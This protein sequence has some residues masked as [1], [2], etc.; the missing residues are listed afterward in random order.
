[1]FGPVSLISSFVDSAWWSQQSQRF[2]VSLINL[3]QFVY[4]VLPC[5]WVAG[6]WFV[7]SFWTEYAWPY[8]RYL[9]CLHWCQCRVVYCLKM[10][11]PMVF[12]FRHAQWLTGWENLVQFVFTGIAST[13]LAHQKFGGKFNPR[14]LCHLLNRIPQTYGWSWFGVLLPCFVFLLHKFYILPLFFVW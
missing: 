11:P 7:N 10:C 2:L 4:H 14:C 12:I 6:T 8:F 9:V 1:M 5:L 3:C 13:V